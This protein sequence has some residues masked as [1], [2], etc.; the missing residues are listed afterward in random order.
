MGEFET[1]TVMMGNGNIIKKIESSKFPNS[2][3]LLYS[4]FTA[5]LGFEVN[6]AEYKVMGMAGFGKPVYE[7]KIRD[8]VKISETGRITV[9][10]GL[11]NVK[12]PT[13]PIFGH[14][15]L[16]MFGPPREPDS[17][18]FIDVA[19]DK[20]SKQASLNKHYADIAASLQ[21]ATE[22]MMVDMVRTV[23]TK[24]GVKAVCLSGGVA[25][26]SLANARMKRE[27][28]IDLYVH[29]SPGDGGTSLG[30]ALAY[31]HKNASYRCESLKSALI[32]KSYTNDE[33]R[34]ELSDRGFPAS[35]ALSQED[36]MNKVASRLADGKVVAWFQGNAE[37][38]PRALGSRSILA[39]PSLKN[40]Q[41]TVNRKVKFREPFR[42][43][44]PAILEK[45][46]DEY[47]EMIEKPKTFTRKLYAL[48]SQ[49][50]AKGSD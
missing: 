29:P 33:V 6:D 45:Y 46:A 42:P 40:M 34:K 4:A 9:E 50:F 30:A 26:N 43:F 39:N 49:S 3:G 5:F 25:L 20:Q 11:L 17:D 35:E 12:D 37:W 10:S 13:K 22:H 31:H 32:G 41:D 44:A 8:L 2:I 16:S 28:D 47:F 7:K 36:M 27:L 23:V 14:K 1:S 15:L 38:G 18:F 24:L 48:D 21:L 19:N